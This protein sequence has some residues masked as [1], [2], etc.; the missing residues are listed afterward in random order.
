[1]GRNKGRGQKR[2]SPSTII[3]C[4]EKLNNAHLLGHIAL[5]RANVL[6]LV[7]VVMFLFT[8]LA[9][10]SKDTSLQ[11]AYRELFKESLYE[12]DQAEA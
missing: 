9:V 1:M 12:E 6:Q 3:I 7:N 2:A 8:L 5:I 4:F 11:L 10:L